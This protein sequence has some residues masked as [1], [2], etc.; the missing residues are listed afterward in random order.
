LG[1]Q[2]LNGLLRH[3]HLLDHQTRGSVPVLDR[4]VDE[5]TD[6]PDILVQGVLLNLLASLK[7]ELV[8]DLLGD[9]PRRT[10]VRQSFK[11]PQREP[12]L[13]DRYLPESFDLLSLAVLLDELLPLEVHNAG[14]HVGV[15]LGVLHVAEVL[16]EGLAGQRLGLPLAAF[17]PTA[18]PSFDTGSF[19]GPGFSHR[20]HCIGGSGADGQRRGQRG[21]A[22]R[23]KL[24][25]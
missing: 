13:V 17:I 4:P 16:G 20:L 8:Q 9:L 2:C 7:D 21:L 25:T 3:L 19:V 22:A 5:R 12:G 23:D 15:E 11:V 1:G 10:W 24:E 14:E 6:V 18:P